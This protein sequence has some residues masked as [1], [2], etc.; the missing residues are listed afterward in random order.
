MYRHHF[1]LIGS[2]YWRFQHSNFTIVIVVQPVSSESDLFFVFFI[3]LIL[4]IHRLIL[5]IFILIF[6]FFLFSIFY[7]KIVNIL[8]FDSNRTPSTTV[9]ESQ[10]YKTYLK[11]EM[12]IFT[13]DLVYHFHLISIYTPNICYCSTDSNNNYLD[14]C[15]RWILKY[16][17]VAQKKFKWDISGVIWIRIVVRVHQ[18]NPFAVSKIRKL[19]LQLIK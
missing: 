14:F 15:W 2:P 1:P 10:S 9:W 3:L 11:V 5:L 17:Q 7:L 19:S 4:I 13:T 16:F 18:Y 6:F 12:P 8:L